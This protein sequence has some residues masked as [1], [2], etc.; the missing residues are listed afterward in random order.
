MEFLSGVKVMF[1]SIEEFFGALPSDNK[2]ASYSVLRTVRNEQ[3]VPTTSYKLHISGIVTMVVGETSVFLLGEMNLRC[4][5]HLGDPGS[6]HTNEQH[7]V[8]EY[9][10][11]AIAA[12]QEL[13]NEMKVSLNRGIITANMQDII[14]G[15]IRAGEN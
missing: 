3:G 9:K 10:K 1:D 7:C 12:I 15:I 13:A 14:F 5:S 8:E 2:V 11:K 6:R 4:G